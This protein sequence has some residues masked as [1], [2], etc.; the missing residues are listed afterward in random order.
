MHIADTWFERRPMDDGITW[1]YEPH[2][3]PFIRC[4]V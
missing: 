3:H 1:I 2:V 4:N